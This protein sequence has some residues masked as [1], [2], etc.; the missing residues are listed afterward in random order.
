MVIA[1]G[2]RAPQLA[3]PS[4][5]MINTYRQPQVTAMALRRLTRNDFRDATWDH[6][7]DV[8]PLSIWQRWST[9]HRH[10]CPPREY[11]LRALKVK[12]VNRTISCPKV[13]VRQDPV[14][15]VPP[16][17]TQWYHGDRTSMHCPVL[18][19]KPVSPQETGGPQPIHSAY[20]GCDFPS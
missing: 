3:Q 13:K 12:Q 5:H 8:N 14:E 15:H 16:G 9:N 18:P 4:T 17:P 11:H 10:P 19:R 20:T 2:L 7:L 6:G 1:S